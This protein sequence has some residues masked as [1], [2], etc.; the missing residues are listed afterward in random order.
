MYTRQSWENYF[1]KVI[2]L[3]QAHAGRMRPT[4]SDHFRAAKVCVCVHP[5]GYK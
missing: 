2:F 3:N 1:M 4:S 5:R